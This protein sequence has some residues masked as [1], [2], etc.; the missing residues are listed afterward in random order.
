MDTPVGVR[1]ELVRPLQHG[2]TERQRPLLLAFEVVHVEVQVKL[3]GT[4]LA[5]PLG[6]PVAVHPLAGQGRPLEAVHLDPFGF[7]RVRDHPP[8]E[9]LR[10]ELRE[11]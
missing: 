2:R 11:P 1:A 8:A 3:L 9:Q 10:V 6:R 5:G 7:V 4:V